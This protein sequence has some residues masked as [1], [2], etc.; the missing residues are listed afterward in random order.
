MVKGNCYK[1]YL[2]V[3]FLLLFSLPST[4]LIQKYFG[5]I[6]VSSYILIVTLVFLFLLKFKTKI[7]AFV[8]RF[9]F[10]VLAITIVFGI[11]SFWILYPLE[12]AGLLGR[13]SDRDEALN[14]AFWELIQGRYPYF[15]TTHLGGQITPLPGAI[16]IAAPFILMGNSAYQNLFWIAVFLCLTTIYLESHVSAIV[17]FIFLAVLSPAFQHEYISGGDLIANS[18]YILIAIFL[19]IKA[20]SSNS[21]I[22]KVST[23]IFTGIALASRSNFLTLL[24]PLLVL[25]WRIAAR[26]V[27]LTYLSLSILT[28]IFIVMPFYLILPDSFPPFFAGNKLNELNVS[29]PFASTGVIALTLLIAVLLSLQLIK[30]PRTNLLRS[31][32]IYAAVIQALPMGCGVF[33]I[34][35]LNQHLDFS[36]LSHRYGLMFLFFALWG[37]WPLLTE[38]HHI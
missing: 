17:M 25:F 12:T 8:S 11:T 37:L 15:A 26:R 14:I 34:S 4:A 36:F 23:S 16:L 7:F 9:Y 22:A 2:L 24:P 33:L 30:V 27:A 35:I 18:I 21:V 32:M 28:L 29:M 10:G 13:G 19:Q 6:G 38:E 20:L 31:F 3:A 1:V 5:L